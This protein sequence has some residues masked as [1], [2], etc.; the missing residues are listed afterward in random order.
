[1]SS[2]ERNRASRAIAALPSIR[3]SVDQLELAAS[4][5]VAIASMRFHPTISG[6]RG[7]ETS[8]V[9]QTT[10]ASFIRDQESL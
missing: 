4:S 8:L 6:K 5:L 10:E 9:K 2:L 1:M 7:R 3:H